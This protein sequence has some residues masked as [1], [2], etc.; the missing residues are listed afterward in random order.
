MRGVKEGAN[1]PCKVCGVVFAR[2]RYGWSFGPCCSLACQ[3]RSYE[4]ESEVNPRSVDRRDCANY[5]RCFDEA[6]VKG[7]ASV[8]GQLGHPDG[9]A[10]YEPDLNEPKRAAA[11]LQSHAWMWEEA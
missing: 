8:C 5:K 10:R 3:R 2:K 7:R 11:E 4:E 1:R 9:C 6:A